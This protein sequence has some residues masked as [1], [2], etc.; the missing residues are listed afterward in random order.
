MVGGGVL[1]PKTR[2]AIVWNIEVSNDDQVFSCFDHVID[3]RLRENMMFIK[4]F[5]QDGEE[6]HYS[7]EWAPGAKTITLK[8]EVV[9]LPCE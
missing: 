4:A 9:D 8:R 6:Y 3:L 1:M 2:E 7:H 5:N